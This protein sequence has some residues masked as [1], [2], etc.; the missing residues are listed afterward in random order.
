LVSSALTSS[1]HIQKSKNR[2]LKA[3]RRRDKYQALFLHRQALA[4][5]RLARP[6]EPVPTLLPETKAE[7]SEAG[8]GEEVTVTP[9][10]A[11][12]SCSQDEQT[13]DWTAPAVGEAVP[14]GDDV[15]SVSENRLRRSSVQKAADHES[16]TDNACK[17]ASSV[18][19]QCDEDEK[20]KELS[21]TDN[22]LDVDH[23][24]PAEVAEEKTETV[25]AFAPRSRTSRRKSS[26]CLPRVLKCLATKTYSA[27]ILAASG[28]P[29]L[30]RTNK[31][32]RCS[33]FSELDRDERDLEDI[34]GEAGLAA[35]DAGSSQIIEPQRGTGE[36]TFP[37][38]DPHSWS[39]ESLWQ[40]VSRMRRQSRI[41]QQRAAFLCRVVSI[42]C[43]KTYWRACE[44]A[45]RETT[46]LPSV[47]L[48]APDQIRSEYSFFL[49]ACTGQYFF[50]PGNL[51]KFLLKFFKVF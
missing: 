5:E 50:G 31:S 4:L 34:L 22:P 7:K 30:Q 29:G 1:R 49:S 38:P 44:E 39:N 8:E 2:E 3:Q 26:A 43:R 48:L 16:L 6:P 14:V 36:P 11:D 51:K 46:S 20:S 42:L 19:N 9:D 13:T 25:K 40:L 12:S 32:S 37:E 47:L 35:A 45:A 10:L 17:P 23:R 33:S 28:K 21:S 15:V 24:V 27:K 41:A 18:T